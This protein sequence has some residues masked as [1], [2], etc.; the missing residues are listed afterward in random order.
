MV[1]L[2][3][4]VGLLLI[5]V[6]L[7]LILVY[8]RYIERKSIFFPAKVIEYS[9][10]QAGLDFEDVFFKT[11]DNTQ[12]N[13][14]FLPHKNARLTFLFC[15]GNA[16]NIGHRIE[17]LKFFHGLGCNVFIFDYRGYGKSKGRPSEQG[18]YQDTQGAYAYLLSRKITPQQIIG[19]GES[20]GGAAIID[21]AS[22]FKLGGL[23]MDSTFSSA[24]DMTGIIYPFLPYWVFASR[25]DSINKVKSIRISKLFIHSVN[26]E[27]VPY[28]LARKLY[29][30]AAAPKDFLEM[31]GAHN[32]CF[33][34]STAAYKEK[35]S[36]FLEQVSP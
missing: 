13:G 34:E 7:G 23:I 25:F 19:Y 32:S 12:L 3:W 36:S 24:K 4:L 1:V 8:I 9:P 27:I 35:I 5:F 22:K 10:K 17:K 31:H 30:S 16:G 20:L 11:Q 33:F 15:H 6:I 21:L 29:E 26:D 2:K 14:W 18:L 28:E